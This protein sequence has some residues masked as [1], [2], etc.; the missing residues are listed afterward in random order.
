V[1]FALTASNP[2]FGR[3]LFDLLQRIE[4]LDLN[5]EIGRR[6][7]LQSQDEIGHVIGRLPIMEIGNRE[8][9]PIVLDERLDSE[10]PIEKLRG[11]LF[12]GAG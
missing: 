12:P 11:R 4:P 10:V 5:N 2:A 6:L 7:S 1:P 9:K 3:L 8:A